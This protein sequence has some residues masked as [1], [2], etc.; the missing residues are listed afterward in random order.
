MSL[1]FSVCQSFFCLS[2]LYYHCLSIWISSPVTLSFSQYIF[3]YISFFF[4]SSLFLSISRSLNFSF[5]HLFAINIS[6][7][8]F[9]APSFFCLSLSL[10]INLYLS[11]ISLFQDILDPLSQWRWFTFYVSCFFLFLFCHLPVLSLNTVF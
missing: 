7:S 10:S 9:I 3:P 11:F 2:F 4:S 6:F 5:S 8:Q 1:N